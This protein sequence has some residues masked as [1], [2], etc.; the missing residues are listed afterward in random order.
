MQPDS[1]EGDSAYENTVV[2]F[3][4][5]SAYGVFTLELI[6]YEYIFGCAHVSLGK[7]LHRRNEETSH[8]WH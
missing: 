7:G 8:F 4:V 5:V 3:A 2:S 6:E 1:A